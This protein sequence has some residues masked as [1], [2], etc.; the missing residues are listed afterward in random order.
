MYYI[1]SLRHTAYREK[2]LTLWRPSNAGYCYSK[3]MA[4]VY[5]TPKPGYHDDHGNMPILVEDAEKLM[6]QFVLPEYNNEPRHMIP[7]NKATLQLLGLKRI[8]GSLTRI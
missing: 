6:K 5:E 2:Y 1:I 8:K 7:N 3:E 4:G